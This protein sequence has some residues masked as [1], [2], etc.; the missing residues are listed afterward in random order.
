MAN[1]T[2]NNTKYA[3][4]FVFLFFSL[5]VQLCASAFSLSVYIYM[6]I[7]VC[8]FV[9]RKFS[10]SCCWLPR[11]FVSESQFVC[12]CLFKYLYV[13][14]HF[15]TIWEC[16]LNNTGDDISYLFSVNKLLS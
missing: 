2:N 6:Y 1:T 7:Y 11:L 8:E 14:M 12:V 13:F 15:D 9:E 4:L 5:W 3:H 10:Q 16:I